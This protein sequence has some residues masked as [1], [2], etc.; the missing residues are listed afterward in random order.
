MSV[1]VH[2]LTCRDTVEERVQPLLDSKAM[3]F[4]QLIDALQHKP[5]TVRHLL[6]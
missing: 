2:F 6:T 4:A 5:E 1:T 3:T